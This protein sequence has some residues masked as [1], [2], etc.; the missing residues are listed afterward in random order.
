[1]TN[2]FIAK[3]KCPENGNNIMVCGSL[4]YS[5]H[6]KWVGSTLHSGQM[7]TYKFRITSF[8][9]FVFNL[10]HASDVHGKNNDVSGDLNIF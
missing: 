9:I 4:N 8:M 2:H 10:G 7:D 6:S 3:S 1:M 5:N